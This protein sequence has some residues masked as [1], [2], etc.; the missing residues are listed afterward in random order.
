MVPFLVIIPVALWTKQVIPALGVG[1]L[2]GS[3]L[4]RP[5]PLGGVQ[6]A[7]Y[8]LVQN[9]ANPTNLYVLGFLYIFG[10]IVQLIQETGGIKGFTAA[11]SQRIRTRRQTLWLIWA[12]VVGTFSAPV[13]RIVTVAPLAKALEQRIPVKKDRLSFLIEGTGL[14]IIVLLPLGTS[15]IGYMVATIALSLR[16]AHIKGNAY[17]LFLASIPYDFFAVIGVVIAFIYTLLGHPRLGHNAKSSSDQTPSLA[18]Q[19]KKVYTNAHR[20]VAD[21]LPT[22]PLNLYVPLGTAVL[23]TL[24]LPWW[25]GYQKTHSIGGAFF[26]TDVPKAMFVGIVLTVLITVGWLMAQHFALDKLMTEFFKG[27]NNLMAPIA[28]F[29]VAWALSSV[30]EKLGLAAFISSALGWVPGSIIAPAIF[31]LGSLLAYFL[32]TSFGAWALIMPIGVSMAHTA[33]VSLP[34]VLGAVFAT[35]TVGELISPFSGDTVTIANIM[36]MDPVAYSR[37]KLKHSLLPITLATLGY[38]L[39]GA[40]R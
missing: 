12:T 25:D 34:V 21:D 33:T 23:L 1:L 28:I 35:G 29:A 38:Y 6:Q 5:T 18:E 24:F 7:S 11:T 2:V 26:H 9:L 36:D 31:L 30:T 20:A 8:Y 10:G 16:N 27:G 32:G 39:V 17:H 37:Y 40:F 13:L 4:V 15:F 3:Y 14:P 19:D 22:K